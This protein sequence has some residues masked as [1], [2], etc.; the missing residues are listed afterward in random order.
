MSIV[1][2]MYSN[3]MSLHKTNHFWVPLGF[4]YPDT[5]EASPSTGTHTMI[6]WELTMKLEPPWCH[7]T[8]HVPETRNRHDLPLSPRLLLK[9]QR[10]SHHPWW[11]LGS[12]HFSVPGIEAPPSFLSVSDSPTAVSHGLAPLSRASR[13]AECPGLQSSTANTRTRG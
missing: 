7:H 3:S 13:H 6:N 10:L 8:S 12:L 5:S 11:V 4:S 2:C 1:S 9:W